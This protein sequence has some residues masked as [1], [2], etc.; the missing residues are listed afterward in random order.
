VKI[1][2]GKTDRGGRE[3]P[4]LS[5]H[6][7]STQHSMA[8]IEPIAVETKIKKRPRRGRCV[9]GVFSALNH[10]SLDKSLMHATKQL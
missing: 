4:S 2:I 8:L 3:R 10:R 1:K 5:V 7:I 6:V 9:Y